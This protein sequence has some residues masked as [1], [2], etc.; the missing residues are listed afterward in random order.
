MRTDFK[1]VC[2]LKQRAANRKYTPAQEAARARAADSI[3]T[4]NRSWWG[5]FS[6]AVQDMMDM[7][8]GTGSVGSSDDAQVTY[9][10]QS[11]C[12]DVSILRVAS[13]AFRIRVSGLL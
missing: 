11:D 5:N 2:R 4:E 3:K 10:I 13:T 7:N 1:G 6:H 8:A 12:C 9:S